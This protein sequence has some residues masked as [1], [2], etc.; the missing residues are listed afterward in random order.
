M[1][2]Y[3]NDLRGIL[4]ARVGEFPGLRADGPATGAPAMG[5]NPWDTSDTNDGMSVDFRSA[6]IRCCGLIGIREGNGRWYRD[7]AISLAAVAWQRAA[8]EVVDEFI[9]E[10]LPDYIEYYDA[11]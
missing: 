7:H 1:K 6:A 10:S 5:F 9:S 4:E 8:C 11:V 3:L 2:K